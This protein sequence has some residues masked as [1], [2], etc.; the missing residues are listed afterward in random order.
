M[1]VA[2]A[3]AVSRA[4][5]AGRE[6]RARRLIATRGAN[7]IPKDCGA[8]VPRINTMIIRYQVTVELKID[9]AAIIRALATLILFLT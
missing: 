7:R 5:M 1:Q 8:V 3:K 6:T 4:A 9:V 2:T